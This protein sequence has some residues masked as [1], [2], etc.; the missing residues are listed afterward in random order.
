MKELTCYERMKCVY[1]HREGDRIPFFDGPWAATVE[2]WHKEGMPK[3]MAWQDY[4]GVDKAA[5][6]GADNSP[7]YECK[8]IEE[9]DE[10]RIFTTQWGATLK[11]FKHSATVPEFISFT[12]TSR[13]KWEEAKKRMTPSMDRVDWKSLKENYKK[14]RKEGLWVGA[15]FWFGFDVSHS[16]MVG[17]EQFLLWLV[18]DPELCVD[19]FNTYL[20]V[21]IALFQKIWDEGYRFDGIGWPDDMGYKHNQ[22]FSLPMYRELLK[23]VHKRAA[24]WAHAKGLKVSLHSCGDVNP[25][26]PDLIEIGIDL[27]NPLEV[28]AGMDPIH[29]KKT[30]GD[31]LALHGG[32]NALNW[33]KPDVIREEISRVVPFMKQNGGYIF[34]SDHS[35]PS[36][37]SL[38]DMKEIVALV[39]E[40]GKY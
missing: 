22:F 24:D 36:D 12:V 21:D 28:K 29:I 35:I 2:R 7:R 38:K 27:L 34:G 19:I 26:I 9:N 23:P 20:D 10:Y 15:H 30:Y 18:E 11:D 3:E 4:F 5:G 1:E 17:T 40:A 25:L 32:I 37:V 16:W 31:R 6:I 39:K 8:T 33:S 14:W 13:E